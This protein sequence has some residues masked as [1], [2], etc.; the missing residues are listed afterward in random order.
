VPL[1]SKAP[2]YS[3]HRNDPHVGDTIGVS[4]TD[5]RTGRTLFYAPGLGAVDVPVAEAFARAD[6]VLVDGTFF[7]EDE[8][9]RLGVGD[10]HARDMGHLPQSGARGMIDVL[11]AYPRAR[12]VLTHVNNTNPILDERSGARAQLDAAGIEVAHDGMELVV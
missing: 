11:A 4:L 8:M 2:P 6:C 9:I 7:T 12:K 1:Q 10:K 3:P 5:Q